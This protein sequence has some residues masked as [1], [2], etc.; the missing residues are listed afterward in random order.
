MFFFSFYSHFRLNKNKVKFNY[1]L[2]YIYI[3]MQ[4]VCTTHCMLRYLIKPGQDSSGLW[5]LLIT[6]MHLTLFK[7]S[8]ESK[9]KQF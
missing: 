1:S 5:T 3:Y 6:L 4:D 7:N 8:N 9:L 2:A